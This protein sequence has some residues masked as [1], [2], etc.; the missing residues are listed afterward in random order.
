MLAA[1]IVFLFVRN[2]R[3]LPAGEEP[4]PRW[5]FLILLV[6]VGLI[7]ASNWVFR[8]SYLHVYQDQ[9]IFKPYTSEDPLTLAYTDIASINS[10]KGTF[11]DLPVIDMDVSNTL[12][13]VTTD[14]TTTEHKL[15]CSRKSFAQ[16]LPVLLQTRKQ[17][18]T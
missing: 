11:I 7:Y 5:L 12:T 9:I 14:G 8:N 17:S 4:T 1:G 3:F 16:V 6:I 10:I 13:I 2:T 15:S 18:I